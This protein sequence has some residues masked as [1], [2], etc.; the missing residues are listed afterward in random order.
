MTESKTSLNNLL[1][2]P[3]ESV[4]GARK[5]RLPSLC[6]AAFSAT[7]WAL[8]ALNGL[9]SPGAYGYWAIAYSVVL[10]LVAWGL[11]QMRKEAAVVALVVALIGLLSGGGYFKIVADILMLLVAVAAIRGTLAYALLTRQAA[12]KSRSHPL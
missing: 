9:F 2:A 10:A 1:F 8:I 7:I 6:L 4:E 11:Y 5:A 3:I 12:S